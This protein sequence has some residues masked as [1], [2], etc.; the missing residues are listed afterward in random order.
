[1]CLY[2]QAGLAA[3]EEQFEAADFFLHP[4]SFA[5]SLARQAPNWELGEST[6]LTP[7]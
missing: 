5:E 4:E 3:A 2:F 6:I 7:D 1:M